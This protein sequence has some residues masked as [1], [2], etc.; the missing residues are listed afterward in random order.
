M[1]ECK[2]WPSGAELLRL[3]GVPTAEEKI[4]HEAK[5]TLVNIL[6]NLKETRVYCDNQARD[7]WVVGVPKNGCLPISMI[8]T[9][10]ILPV[11]VRF[12][13]GSLDGAVEILIQHPRFRSREED[14]PGLGFDLSAMDKLEKRWLAAWKE[15]GI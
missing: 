2:F 11:L 14:V 15:V 13:G 1:K 5:D 12:G 6:D 8:S 10:K 3:A 9:E 4:E 7:M